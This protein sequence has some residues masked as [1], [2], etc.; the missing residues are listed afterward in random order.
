MLI[1]RS[2][3]HTKYPANFQLI[4]AMNP[5]KCG[6]LADLNRQCSKAPMCGQT[7]L[8]KI[9]GPILD[10]LSMHVEVAN[11]NTYNHV[12]A[13]NESSDIVMKRITIARNR[14]LARYK[15]QGI[16]TNARVNGQLLLKS[17]AL[18][19]VGQKLLDKTAEKFKISMRGYTT[20]LRVALTIADL[21]GSEYVLS[22]HIAESIS[23]RLTDYTSG[24]R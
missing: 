11:S 15:T 19:N 5:C 4:A 13:E 24:L 2:N 12:G 18:D 1:S 16:I 21:E 10:R 8:T 22:H 3:W 9:S 14:Q 20:I 17:A 6:Y 7:Y 23:Y